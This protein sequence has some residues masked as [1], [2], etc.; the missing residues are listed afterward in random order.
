MQKSTQGHFERTK[1]LRKGD[2]A[3]RYHE[4]SAYNDHQTGNVNKRV[5]ATTQKYGGNDYG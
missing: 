4:G 1:E 2:L 5:D 3:E